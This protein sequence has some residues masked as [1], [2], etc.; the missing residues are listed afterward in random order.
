MAFFMSPVIIFRD[1]G[2][3][4]NYSSRQMTREK[5]REREREREK[6]RGKG[7]S[8]QRMDVYGDGSKSF[9]L[10]EFLVFFML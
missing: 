10:T 6:E 8:G 4:N 2:H 3:F 5:E 9:M 1:I 7:S